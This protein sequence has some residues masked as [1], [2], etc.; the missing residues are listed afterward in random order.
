MG[1]ERSEGIWGG[2]LAGFGGDL[3]GTWVVLRGIYGD[4]RESGGISRRGSGDK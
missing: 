1:V 3:G 4:L 2:D